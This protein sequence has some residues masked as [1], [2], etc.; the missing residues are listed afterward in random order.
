[1]SKRKVP[2]T[3]RPIRKHG[4]SYGIPCLMR[5]PLRQ[6]LRDRK[7][8]SIS[9]IVSAFRDEISPDRASQVFVSC[10]RGGQGDRAELPL[11][12][13]IEEGLLLLVSDALNRSIR[14]GLLEGRHDGRYQEVRLAEWFCWSC[15]L[16]MHG[17]RQ[18]PGLCHEC[19]TAAQEASQDD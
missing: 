4:S 14:D 13:Q 8:W 12:V 6:L 9:R 2:T 5:D 1:M 3:P 7:W 19:L 10:S 17:D 11:H 15:G 18:E 16:E